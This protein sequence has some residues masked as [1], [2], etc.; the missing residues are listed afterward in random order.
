[1]LELFG[2]K[3]GVEAIGLDIGPSSV[4]VVQIK[5]E[6]DRLVLVTYGEVAL[7]PYAGLQIG[8][9]T[10]L[11]DEKL[12]EAIKDLFRE[13]KVT[14]SNATLSIESSSAYVSMITVPRVEDKELRTMMPLEARKYI[15]IPA[16]ELQIDWWHLPDF[17]YDST[18][19]ARNMNVVLAA[20]KNETVSM[21]DRIVKQIGLT[22]VDFE[23]EGFSL[24]RSV[25]RG[26]SGLTLCLDVGSE[27]STINL[28]HSGVVID[29]N[30]IGHGS[31]ESTIQ[32]SK[33]LALAVDVAEETKR[34]F[35]YYGD[36]ANPFVKE[37]M[38]LSSYPL[39]G[40]VARLSLMYEKKYNQNIEGM[41]ICG[42]GARIPGI[43]DAYRQ[44]SHIDAR[45][46]T[47]FDQIAIPPFL[48]EMIERIGPTYSIAVGLA[49]KKL[50]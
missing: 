45:I 30:V 48:Q 43:V 33:A 2:K 28:I 44:I 23:I 16:T 22:N 20:V 4:K 31:Q 41:I 17:I 32:L 6:N 1:M 5:R 18:K 34:T 24:A 25:L 12:I 40:E 27:Y 10:K 46:A 15:P 21:Y 19:D 3:S 38:T 50:F 35:G 47:P 9:A 39:F 14:S 42:G 8:Q 13:A 26:I 29:M 37:V 49:L 7:G 36:E 11:G